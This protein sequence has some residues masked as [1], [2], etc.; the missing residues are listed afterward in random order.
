MDDQN[1]ATWRN[2]ML[3]TQCTQMLAQHWPN[4]EPILSI[5]SPLAGG[6]LFEQSGKRSCLCCN[7]SALKTRSVLI[8]RVSVTAGFY[9]T[10]FLKRT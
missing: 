9:Q 2:T 1:I 6:L 8:K 4:I 7:E 5:A 3:T 10:I